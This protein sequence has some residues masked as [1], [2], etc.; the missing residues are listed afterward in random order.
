M[1]LNNSVT[2]YNEMTDLVDVGRA[3]NTGYLDFSNGFS[4]VFCDIIIVKLM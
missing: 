2:F 3:V 1:C 4:S